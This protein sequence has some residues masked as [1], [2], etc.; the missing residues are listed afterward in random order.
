MGIARMLQEL[1]EKQSISRHSLNR[2]N[3]VRPQVE[4]VAGLLQLARP[5]EELELWAGLACLEPL[6]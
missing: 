4:P 2:L 1:G 6:V 3:K 5:H